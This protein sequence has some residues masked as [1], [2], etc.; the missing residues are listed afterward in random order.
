MCVVLPFCRMWAASASLARHC[1]RCRGGAAT[2]SMQQHWATACG[3]FGGPSPAGG[4]SSQPGARAHTHTHA[5]TPSMS[6]VASSSRGVALQHTAAVQMRALSLQSSCGCVAWWRWCGALCADG[7][8]TGACA[9]VCAAGSP[10]CAARSVVA[11]CGWLH[12]RSRG[13][14]RL[15][16]RCMGRLPRWVRAPGCPGAPTVSRQHALTRA[17]GLHAACTLRVALRSTHLH[18]LRCLT[19]SCCG[20]CCLQDWPSLLTVLAPA[21]SGRCAEVAEVR[22]AGS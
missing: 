21:A 11:R 5:R 12:T 22:R 17:G 7:R 10:A 14:R 13:R 2:S 6:A 3:T 9:C 1:S 16:P 20:C 18:L 8:T 4:G 19:V 15:S